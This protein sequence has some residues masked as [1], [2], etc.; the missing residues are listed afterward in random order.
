MEVVKNNS[1]IVYAGFKKRFLAYI[2][3]N[4]FVS[5]ISVIEVTVIG[6]INLNINILD[7]LIRVSPRFVRKMSIR[8]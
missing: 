6:F 8:Q 5:I 4:I 3:D 2:L 7:I 1:E